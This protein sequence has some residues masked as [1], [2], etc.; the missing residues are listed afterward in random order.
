MVGQLR[1]GQSFNIVGRVAGDRWLLVEQNGYVT[2]YVAEW[3][4]QPVASGGG[5]ANANC[6]LVQQT[7]QPRMGQA[8]TERYTAC[9]EAGGGWRLS[10]A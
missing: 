8:T 6:K 1:G 3:V 5:Y 9:P 7:I 10:A 4:V 2:G